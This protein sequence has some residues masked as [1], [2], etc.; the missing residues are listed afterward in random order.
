MCWCWCWP[1]KC[2]G[3]CKPAP[4]VEALV[5]ITNSTKWINRDF[6]HYMSFRKTKIDKL[7]PW[8]HHAQVHKTLS[9]L[10][11]MGGKSI[12]KNYL[13]CCFVAAANTTNYVPSKLQC[14][15]CTRFYCASLAEWGRLQRAFFFCHSFS[16][17]KVKLMWRVKRNFAIA[18]NWRNA[19]VEHVV[20]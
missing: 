6:I 17:S 10:H 14:S 5:T 2:D 13:C 18:K 19:S 16:K 7:D 4:A 3:W 20:L 12:K 11:M 9:C 8:P 1:F 15:K